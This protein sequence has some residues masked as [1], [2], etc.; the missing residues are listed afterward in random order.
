MSDMHG[1]TVLVTGATSGIGLATAV[2][3]ARMGAHVLVHGRTDDSSVAAAARISG[4]AHSD[5]VTH[6]SAD[7][8]SLE[9]VRRLAEAVTGR[10]ERLDVLVNNAG[11][12]MPTRVETIDGLETTWAVNHL[13]HFILTLLLAELLTES[14][15]A[16]VIHVSSV[17]H[18]RGAVDLNDLDWRRREYDGYLAYAASKLM[19]VLFA[20]ELGH[21]WAGTGITSNAMH[22]GVIDTKLLMAGFP[23]QRG[24]SPELGAATAVYLATS[25]EVEDTTG[26]YF[27]NQHAAR[28]S[29]SADDMDLRQGLWRV[30]E[31]LS[32]VT[33]D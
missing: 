10:V 27:V 33:Y 2:Q 5:R 24:A 25:P 8:S 32:G 31:R 30:C 7:L 28:A 18:F 14:T 1:K 20:F 11:V 22:P 3:L 6:V 9:D 29:Q 26:R 19:N 12:F 4:D 21:R 16:R 15:P 23:G 17:A 13:A